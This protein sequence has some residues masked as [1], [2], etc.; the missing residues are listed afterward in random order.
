MEHQERSR[1]SMAVGIVLP[2]HLS[3]ADERPTVRVKG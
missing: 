3:Q 2:Y 1:E